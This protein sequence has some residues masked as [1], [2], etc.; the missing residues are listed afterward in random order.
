MRTINQ[1]DTLSPIPA[2]NQNERTNKLPPECV[3]NDVKT[4]R[5]CESGTMVQVLA[6]SGNYIWLDSNW[7]K[8]AQ[9]AK[10]VD[11]HAPDYESG[12]TNEEEKYYVFFDHRLKVW[13]AGTEGVYEDIGKVYMPENVAKKLADDLNNGRVE[14]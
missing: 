11:E 2:W 7:F 12:W 8:K 1:G 10:Y 5:N 14:L 6:N 3:V 4:V 13:F 9:V